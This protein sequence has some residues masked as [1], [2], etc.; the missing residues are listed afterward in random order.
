MLAFTVKFVDVLQS[1]ALAPEPLTVHVPVPIVSVL[2]P[3]PD[4]ENVP[5]DTL[6]VTAFNVPVV[7]VRALVVPSVKLLARVYVP[8]PASVNGKSCVVAPALI[9]CDEVVAKVHAFVPA[10]SVPAV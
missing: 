1:H 9:V 10:V 3:D 8:E 5:T 7:S 2:T 4:E 6:Y